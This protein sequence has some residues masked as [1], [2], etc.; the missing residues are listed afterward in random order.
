MGT[1]EGTQG[2]QKGR[3][4][5]LMCPTHTVRCLLGGRRQHCTDLT[6]TL[7][8]TWVQTLVLCLDRICTKE[9]EP[10]G[11]V[12]WPLTISPSPSTTL[13]RSHTRNNTKTS[14][15]CFGSLCHADSWAPRNFLQLSTVSL[16]V[17]G[18]IHPMRTCW[19]S[20]AGSARRAGSCRETSMQPKGDYKQEGNQLSYTG[21]RRQDKEGVI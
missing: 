9:E 18:T 10:A 5:S 13:W 15:I 2:M 19:R 8:M 17:K 21:E 6:H 16:S 12:L 1:Q 14:Y 3:Q 11:V 4:P 20:W 7:L